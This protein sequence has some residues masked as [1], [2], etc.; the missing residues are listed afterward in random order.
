VP[1]GNHDWRNSKG[2]SA[3]AG[4]DEAVQSGRFCD[5][6]AQ[7]FVDR[8]YPDARPRKKATLVD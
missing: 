2:N 5:S 3:V 6:P 4:P 7:G 1:S 8:N